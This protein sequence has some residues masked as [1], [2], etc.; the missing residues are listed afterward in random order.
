MRRI[1]TIAIL[2]G[3][4]VNAQ[5]PS[6]RMF[7]VASIKP[8]RSGPPSVQGNQFAYLPGGRFTATNVTLVDVIVQAYPTRRIQMRG[9]PD[10]IDAER[11][12]VVA[13]AD[14]ADGEVTREQWLTMMQTLLEDRFKLKLH[15]ENKES[16]VY[17]LVVAKDATKLQES[18]PE[19][20]H[21]AF[22]GER[23]AMSF[24][25]TPVV[26]LVNTLANVLHEPVV[27]GTGITGLFNFSVNPMELATP[28]RTD[29]SYAD[30]FLRAVEQLG[31]KLEKQR[32]P[33]AI[34]V[35]DHA[36]R[37]SGN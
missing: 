23:G 30:L 35:I 19:D 17:V 24:K 31:F 34:T 7:E 26:A 1:T 18:K 22:P 32:R 16:Q 21:G 3:I 33:L 37:P 13:K 4:V 25:R 12:D 11:W 14:P 29:E 15:V 10:W 9:G 36:E 20:E 28:G 8:N 2:A 27:D 6:R 5:S